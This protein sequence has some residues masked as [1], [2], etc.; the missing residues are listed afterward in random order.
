[1]ESEGKRSGLFE[2]YAITNNPV[3]SK[4]DNI[5]FRVSTYLIIKRFIDI[6][7]SVLGLITVLPVIVLFIILIKIESPGPAFFIQ[8][9]VGLRGKYFNIIKLRSMQL[10]AERDGAQW[11]MKNDPRITKVGAFIR[12]TRI[13]ELPQLINVIKGEM[14]LIGPRPERPIF[15]AQFNEEISGFIERLQ[16]KPG[17]TGWAQINGGYELSPKEKFILDKYYINNLGFR[18]DLKILL[19]TIKVCITG[20][21]AR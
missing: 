19:Q 13:D 7:L 2:E 3:E 18:L 1:M 21:G 16:V 12:K 9:R 5:S 4:I 8:E 20:D 6:I 10:E 15:T 14:S 11:A 17:L